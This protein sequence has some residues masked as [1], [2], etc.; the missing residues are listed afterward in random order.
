V[1]VVQVDCLDMAHLNMLVIAADFTTRNASSLINASGVFAYLGMDLVRLLGFHLCVGLLQYRARMITNERHIIPK[2]LLIKTRL[3]V[4][5]PL[6]VVLQTTAFP[7]RQTAL[8][9]PSVESNPRHPIYKIGALPLSYKG[10]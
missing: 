9:A 5:T 10:I 4:L 2:G 8:R 1:I 3:W 7:F 6:M